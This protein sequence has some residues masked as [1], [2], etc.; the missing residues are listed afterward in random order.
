MQNFLNESS[1]VQ[2]GKTMDEMRLVGRA[3][4]MLM[5]YL[6]MSETAALR[7]IEKRASDMQVS[8]VEIAKNI[9]KTYEP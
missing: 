8:R 2:G 5:L 9:L 6:N 3:K 4:R 1:G 7:Y